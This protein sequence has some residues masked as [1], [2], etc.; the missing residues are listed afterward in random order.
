MH[1]L[2]TA[3]HRMAL[4]GQILIAAAA[5]ITLVAT[6]GSRIPDYA[7]GCEL[8]LADRVRGGLSL[9]VDPAVGAHD[10]GPVPARFLVPYTPVYPWLLARVSGGLAL[11]A[12]RGLGLISWLVALALVATRGGQRRPGALTLFFASGLVG[13]LLLTR[14]AAMVRPDALALFLV[15]LALS[16][17]LR[18]GQASPLDAS[19]FVLGALLKPNVFASGLAALGVT[20]LLS[21]RLG[22]LSV[23]AAALTALL[24]ITALH[25][26]SGGAFFSHLGTAHALAFTLRQC[27]ERSLDRGLFFLPL[28]GLS[29]FFAFQRRHEPAAR[30]GSAALLLSLA[31]ASAGFGKPGAAD[32]Y[33][34]EPTLAA[35]ALLA[36]VEPERLSPRA[37]SGTLAAVLFAFAW[38]LPASTGR[39]RDAYVV[40]PRLAAAVAAARRGCLRAPGDLVLSN[41]PGV[42]YAVNGRIYT[43]GL[44]LLLLALQGRYPLAPWIADVSSPH[45]TC[46]LSHARVPAARPDGPFPEEVKAALA[47]RLTLEGCDDPTCLFRDLGGLPSR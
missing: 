38:G 6:L 5:L 18:R 21:P 25:V 35:L 7:E 20:L 19:L 4:V 3:V 39:I 23:A 31:V 15:A 9:Y 28:F 46:F 45:V 47:E 29:L 41:D 36:R 2:L 32:N 1:R 24:G 16:R 22:A 8:F 44:E 11:Q 17:S 42:E 14:W 33:L 13:S 40:E 26:A 12:G 30:M 43:H 10:Y 27:L 37:L 34:L